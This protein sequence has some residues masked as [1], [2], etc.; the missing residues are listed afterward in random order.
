MTSFA[1][2]ALLGWIPVSLAVFLF[3]LARHTVVAGAIS[4]WL[5]LPP[6]GSGLCGC[7]A[8]EPLSSSV[9]CS[10]ASSWCTIRGGTGWPNRDT[11]MSK[12]AGSPPARDSS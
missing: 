2:I 11:G 12:T 1:L 4:G 6:V 10:T 7:E 8:Y 9:R 5:L 3:L